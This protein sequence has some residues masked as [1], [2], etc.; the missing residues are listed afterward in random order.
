[1][2]WS[3]I[4]MFVPFMSI[5]VSSYVFTV[6]DFAVTSNLKSF[7]ERICS[8]FKGGTYYTSG[9]RVPM[10]VSTLVLTS[11]RLDLVSLVAFMST[12][13]IDSTCSEAC[14]DWRRFWDRLSQSSLN[15]WELLFLSN[16]LLSWRLV[17]EP[18]SGST[19]I[20]FWESKFM[21][22]FL[23]LSARFYVSYNNLDSLWQIEFIYS[24]ILSK[25]SLWLSLKL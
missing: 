12:C 16:Y 4:I 14:I 15:S 24:K 8:S 21:A 3:E 9:A 25:V 10:K 7:W 11:E 22:K 13:K 6:S 5:S 18:S 23:V 2:T 20:F 19:W 17:S 1:M